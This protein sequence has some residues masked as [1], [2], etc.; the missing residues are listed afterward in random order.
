MREELESQIFFVG[1]GEDQQALAHG[2]GAR[3]LD[4]RRAGFS[5]EDNFMYVV[6]SSCVAYKS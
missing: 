1:D 3:A 4:A 2:Q 6:G 5:N